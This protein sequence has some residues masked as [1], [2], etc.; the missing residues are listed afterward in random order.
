MLLIIKSLNVTN[1]VIVDAQISSFIKTIF[2]SSV[3]LDITSDLRTTLN[4]TIVKKSNITKFDSSIDDSFEQNLDIVIP[5]QN[6][7]FFTSTWGILLIVLF[8]II[9]I[10]IAYYFY[11]QKN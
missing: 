9:I 6:K 11:Y 2:E 7:S 5:E 3:V 8:I 1:E 10:S 4:Q